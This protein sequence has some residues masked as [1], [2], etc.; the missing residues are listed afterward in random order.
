VDD[1]IK[2]YKISHD[3]NILNEIK[4]IEKSQNVE[5]FVNINNKNHNFIL[6]V[7]FILFII[8]LYK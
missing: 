1:I 3:D 7:L 5:T 6:I 8:F 4:D 2:N